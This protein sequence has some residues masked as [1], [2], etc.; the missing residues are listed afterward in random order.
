MLLQENTS[1]I[2][3]TKATITNEKP[4]LEY[5]KKNL[6]YKNHTVHGNTRNTNISAE[7]YLT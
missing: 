7:S 4:R 1:T 3:K 6:T 5:P 2:R